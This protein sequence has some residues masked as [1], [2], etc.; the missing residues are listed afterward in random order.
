MSRPVLLRSLFVAALTASF[1]LAATHARAEGTNL[2]SNPGFEDGLASHDWMPAAWDTSR[3]GTETVF[4][5]RDEYSAHTGK[6][7]VSV[8]NASNLLP[9]WHNWSQTIDISPDMWGKDLVMKVWTKNNGVDGRGYVLLQAFRDTVG[10][11]ARQLKTSREIASRRAGFPGVNDPVADL[12]WKR[13]SFD[14][15]ETDWVEREARVF[16]APTV[17]LVTLRMG[18]FGTGQVMFD[19]ASIELEPA[20][21][22]AELPLRTNL[23]QDP[24]F[25]GN[26]LAWELSTPPFPRFVAQRDTLTAAHTGK[27]SMHFHCENGVVSGRAGVAQVIVNRGLAGKRVRLTG[28]AKAESLQSQI[29]LQIFCHTRT[30]MKLEKSTMQVYG[31]TDWKPLIVETDVPED[32]YAIWAWIMYTAPVPGHAYFDD[33]SFEVLGPATGAPTPNDW[34]PPGSARGTKAAAPRSKSKPTT[35]SRASNRAR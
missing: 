7:G 8:A 5:G 19:D 9:L 23:I 27:A 13:L 2:L 35:T 17:D 18:L 32:T 21:P 12:A 34:S 29:G 24:S 4:F 26:T 15:T 10:K 3:A 30:G 16:L 20:A 31:N 14:D 33:L 25:E 11:V 1:V 6:F 22:P 28:F